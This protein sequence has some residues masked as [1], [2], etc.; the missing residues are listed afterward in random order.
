MNNSTNT[1]EEKETFKP[2][3]VYVDRERIESITKNR[4]EMAEKINQRLAMATDL[5]GSDLSDEELTRVA[6]EQIKFIDET[7]KE[8]FQFPKASLEFNLEASGKLDAYNELKESFRGIGRFIDVP[9]LEVENG[10]AIL[11]D[12]GKKEIEDTHTHHTKNEMQNKLMKKFNII[13]SEVNDLEDIGVISNHD[14]GQIER[15]FNFLKHNYEKYKL[16]NSYLLNINV[17]DNRGH[18]PR[19]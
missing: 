17:K 10:K 9:G 2:V 4:N 8:N 3:L 12:A 16:D 15:S 6:S 5:F 1:M 19:F 14:R 18:N 11:T 13:I 7:L